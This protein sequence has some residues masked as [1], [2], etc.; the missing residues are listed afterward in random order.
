VLA[1]IERLPRATRDY[2]AAFDL[3]AIALYREGRIGVT[4]RRKSGIMAQTP[5][6][7]LRQ[8][9]HFMPKRPA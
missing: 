1:P 6:G 8:R 5:Q 4:R 2:I 7:R 9:P 3:A